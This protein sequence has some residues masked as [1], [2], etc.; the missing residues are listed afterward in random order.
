MATAIDPNK[1]QEFKNCIKKI[2]EENA[3]KDS[4]SYSFYDPADK[5]A[6]LFLSDFWKYNDFDASKAKELINVIKGNMKHHK[7][8]DDLMEF[9]RL[10]QE[11]YTMNEE[12]FLAFQKA[13]GG[14]QQRQQSQQNQSQSTPSQTRT[15]SRQR[16]TQAAPPQP[17]VQPQSQS[18]LPPG[19]QRLDY[20]DGN[21]YIGA[22]RNGVPNGRG[23]YFYADGS[24]MEGTFVN[25]RLTDKNAVCYW[26][27]NK[28]TDRGE[29]TNDSRTGSGR[30]EWSNGSW[31]QGEWADDGP[32]GVG[33]RYFSDKKRKDTGHYKNGN[34]SGSGKMEWNSGDTYEGTWEDTDS[35]LQG[36]GVYTYADG[37][38]E[39][40]KWVDGE[41]IVTGFDLNK[42]SGFGAM[43]W[44]SIPWWPWV[45]YGIAVVVALF[46]KSFWGIVGT[47]IFG[48]IGAGIAWWILVIGQGILEGIRDFFI[49]LPK[50]LRIGLWV[51]LFALIGNSVW[52]NRVKPLLFPKTE[53]EQVMKT[54]TVTARSL[55]LRAEPKNNAKVVKALT[56]G[57]VVT[58]TG[59][60]V[61]GW[62]PVE[63]GTSKGYVSASYI[64]EVK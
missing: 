50:W 11:Y 46:T 22:V 40:C 10:C 38:R 51:L 2:T 31:Y 59:E 61:N 5:D 12:T 23:K 45:I 63:Y 42:L 29:Y 32:N 47:A 37:R 64:E 62:V 8:W 41:Y 44:D 30:I 34:R 58:I 52:K 18:T 26:A 27:K 25:G 39:K 36:K 6:F 24:W 3:S 53:I 17:Q 7:Q 28:I 14:R 55:N 49:E 54:A 43:V 56:K 48:A 21:Y 35:G 15:E 19:Q 13:M 60:T 4:A 1:V 57:N 33:T 16:S 20:G 9:R